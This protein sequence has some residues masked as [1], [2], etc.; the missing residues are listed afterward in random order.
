MMNFPKNL[1]VLLLLLPLMQSKA[2][3][4]RGPLVPVWV[5]VMEG[6][7]VTRQQLYNESHALLLGN[8]EYQHW[9]TLPNVN[10]ELDEIGD[11]LKAQGFSVEPHLNLT[12]DQMR[13]TLQRFKERYGYNRQARLLVF[14][15]GHGATLEYYGKQ[16]GYLVP[17]DAPLPRDGASAFKRKALEISTIT[18]ISREMEAHHVLFLLDSCFS[19]SLLETMGE[20]QN[21][22]AVVQ[23]TR[24]PVRQYITAG[25]AKQQV[26]ADSKFAASVIDALKFGA[27]DSNRDGYTTGSELGVYLEGVVPKRASPH[28]QNPQYAKDF[29]HV[30]HMGNFV[31]AVGQKSPIPQSAPQ[32]P[33]PPPSPTMVKPEMVSLKGG[34]FTMG[35]SEKE[36]EWLIEQVG[37]EKYKKFYSDERSHQVTVKRFRLAKREV[38]V[39]QWSQFVESTGYQS[40]AEKRGSCRAWES[41]DG[42]GDR[43]WAWWGR[44]N[45][46]QENEDQHPVSCISWNDAM[47]YI[48]WLN[49][50]LDPRKGYRL[51]T[52]AEWEYAA[53]GGT[54]TIRYWGDDLENR[55]GCRYAQVAG[56]D[57]LEGG[58]QFSTRFSCKDGNAYVGKRGEKLANDY[59]LYDILG[60]VWEWSSSEYSSKYDGSELKPSTVGRESGRRVVRGGSWSYSPWFVRA[61][62]RSDRSPAFRNYGLGFR[63]AQDL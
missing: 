20:S 45:R 38:S 43:E 39:T 61:A 40:D 34:R 56:E 9:D 1:L 36:K 19:G 52:E 63:L 55:E 27:A 51:P 49:R 58:A 33:I 25:T 18:H 10:S 8:S 15:A 22:A 17:V 11:V 14:Y 37:E 54:T 59:G 4:M 60:N 32:S 62:S 5:D 16:K 30:S 7:E 35:Q 57:K 13:T 42:W 3:E 46:Y 28:P 6:D 2:A 48:D 44:P 29:G 53:R 12:A 31:F 23:A 24:E 41:G 21:E 47:A 50:E 26:L